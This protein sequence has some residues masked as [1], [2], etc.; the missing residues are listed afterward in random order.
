MRVLLLPSDLLVATLVVSYALA[1]D[2]Y[3]LFTHR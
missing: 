3:T 2:S 1:L